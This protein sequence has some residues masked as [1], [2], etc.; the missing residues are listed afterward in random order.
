MEFGQETGRDCAADGPFRPSPPGLQPF[1]HG[2]AVEE[3][4]ARSG[5][6]VVYD[7]A[8]NESAFGPSPR[9]LEAVAGGLSAAWRYPD[10]RCSALRGA[11]AGRLGVSPARLVFGTGSE[12]LIEFIIRATIGPGD[13]ILIAPPTFPIYANLARALGGE[14]VCA[15]R[16]EAY[17]IE[18]R[19]L[20]MKLE[21]SVR[22]VFLCNPNN[23]TGTRIEPEELDRIARLVGPRCL[24]VV[25]EAYQEFA[26]I[27]HPTATLATLER[28]GARYVVLRTF[29]KA[30]GLG[31]YRVGYGIASDLEVVE[32]LELVRTQFPVPRISELAALAAWQDTHYTAEVVRETRSRRDRLRAALA[33][34]GWPST[35]SAA[36]FLFVPLERRVDALERHLLA[37]GLIVRRVGEL[38]IRITVGPPDA[39]AALISAA[40]SFRS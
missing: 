14:V 36:N 31:G 35:P 30:F 18:P 6:D 26:D 23:P 19:E 17:R 13:A 11:I 33:E 2:P 3:A 22:T 38:G 8:S 21:P 39:N 10:P 32:R 37:A 7:L 29:S 9:V 24:I 28:T 20:A 15:R 5:R 1:D 34:L 40:R 12:T 25:D 27:E 16:D 4:H